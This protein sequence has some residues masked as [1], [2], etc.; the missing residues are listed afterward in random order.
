MWRL[1]VVGCTTAVMLAVAAEAQDLPPRYGSACATC[2]A[3][4]RTLD[5]FAAHTQASADRQ[6]AD[7]LLIAQTRG[8]RLATGGVLAGIALAS[9]GVLLVPMHCDRLVETEG[10][11]CDLRRR[12]LA[13]IS[14]GMTLAL[15]GSGYLALVQP[16][17]EELLARINAW[18]G[19]HPDAPFRLRMAENANPPRG[20]ETEIARTRRIDPRD[21]EIIARRV[22]SFWL[23]PVVYV[24]MM[25][26][27]ACAT[28]EVWFAMEFLDRQRSATAVAEQPLG[29]RGP[30]VD[31]KPMLAAAACTGLS[32]GTAAV[33]GYSRS[34]ALPAARSVELR[35][36]LGALALTASFH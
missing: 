25:I 26:G 31:A 10:P 36:G 18:N 22:S 19:T 15:M 6:L 4:A 12:N 24:P 20:G 29:G 9:V 8:E 21:A 30:E 5:A 17:E 13:L 2:P 11:W 28:A 34:R 35:L 3:P 16:R 27:A 23:D 14:A 1:D 32:F 7:D 33:V